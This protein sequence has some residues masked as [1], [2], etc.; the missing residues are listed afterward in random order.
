MAHQEAFSQRK[1]V[2]M[3]V[4]EADAGTS[5]WRSCRQMQVRCTQAGT[6]QSLHALLLHAHGPARFRSGKPPTHPPTHPPFLATSC[7]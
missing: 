3:E 7:P 6:P 2:I 4:L 5:L 1:A